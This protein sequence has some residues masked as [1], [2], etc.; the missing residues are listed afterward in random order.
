VRSLIQFALD[1]SDVATITSAILYLTTA[2]AND[3]TVEDYLRDTH[4]TWATG[5]SY[6]RQLTSSWNAGI[7]GN[8][9]VWYEDN[10][11]NWLNK[12]SNNGST[13]RVSFT[14]DASRPASP[15]AVGID[16]TSMV[17]SWFTNS[18]VNYGLELSAATETTT[19]TTFSEYYSSHAQSDAGI[20][21][22]VG[23][24]IELTYTAVT[25]SRRPVVSA[26]SPT[27][28]NV[29][30]IANLNDGSLWSSASYSAGPEIKWS[31]TPA[32]TAA[33]TSWRLRIWE[34]TAAAGTQVFESGT[35][36]G[37]PYVSYRSLALGTA[38]PDW[39]PGSGWA[40]GKAGLINGSNYAWALVAT[41]SNGSA[42]SV[43]ATPFKVRWSQAVYEFDAGA[44]WSQTSQWSVTPNIPEKNTSIGIAHRA[45]SATDARNG[46]SSLVYAKGDAASM[47]YY[48]AS[49]NSYVTN[50]TSADGT[51]VTYA[52]TNTFSVGD[53]ISVSGI[54]TSAQYNLSNV[55]VTAATGTSFT[56]ASNATGAFSHTG[57]NMPYAFS[58]H[59]FNVGQRINVSGITTSAGT[60]TYTLRSQTQLHL[61]TFHRQVEHKRLPLK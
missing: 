49:K 54:S 30:R 19:N 25:A 37:E 40:A 27:A 16:I 38:N 7:R 6:V 4:G 47:T 11:V 35:V 58:S 48:L 36:T 10:A 24:Y 12:P 52:G 53:Y 33:I 1:F 41:D 21:G 59:P 23:P 57:N 14:P 43:V 8:D 44:S 29:A 22:A 55:N 60:N 46:S 28:S 51:L 45:L 15:T 32:G 61:P 13:N 50:V 17:S 18:Y 2:R 34:G 42:G 5:T 39:I 20:A 26:V 56:V 9:E 31:I 3:G